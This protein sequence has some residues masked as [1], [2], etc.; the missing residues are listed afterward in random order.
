MDPRFYDMNYLLLLCNLI[1][2]CTFVPSELSWLN[3]SF[4]FLI[5][6]FPSSR[7]CELIRQYMRMLIEEL[8]TK[9]MKKK[10][11]IY[12]ILFK[13]AIKLNIQNY[14]Y[15][16]DYFYLPNMRCEM[17]T[18]MLLQNGHGSRFAFSH[19]IAFLKK[20]MQLHFQYKHQI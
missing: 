15:C 16:K 20:S 18:K 19:T 10:Q 2:C 4:N 17:W 13:S 11:K 12:F 9:M 3:L 8:M 5:I 6:V 14:M 1:Y 7:N